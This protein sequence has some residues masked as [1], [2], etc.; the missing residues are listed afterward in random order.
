M[1]DDEQPADAGEAP[2]PDAAPAPVPAQD[3]TP[4][5]QPAQEARVPLAAQNEDPSAR[6]AEL[7]AEL[8]RIRA[9]ATAGAKVLV[10]VLEPHVAF[11]HGG[12]T[13]GAVPTPVPQSALSALMTAAAEAGVKLIEEA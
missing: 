3:V 10:R 1:A 4:P 11:T 2:V 13:V 6:A 8:A 7:E 12:I 5:Q 9:D